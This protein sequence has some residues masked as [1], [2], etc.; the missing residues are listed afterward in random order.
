MT[1]I[2]VDLDGVL[3]NF[4][5]RYWEVTGEDFS[6]IEDSVVRWGKLKGKE[7]G[8]YRRI[9]P[10]R[11]YEQFMK[12]LEA[13]SLRHRFPL[14]VLTALPTVIEFDTAAQEKLDWCRQYLNLVF[15]V[16]IVKSSQEKQFVCNQGDILI[17]DNPRNVAQWM[18]C[19]G[20]A[21]R[22]IDFQDT[23]IQLGELL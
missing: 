15:P 4:T 10:F 8:F 21:I 14:R 3:A 17:D 16:L 11:G 13:K 6:E 9:L 2:Y 18:N 22:H 23:L 20:I 19:G 7:E 5:E 12:E 1:G